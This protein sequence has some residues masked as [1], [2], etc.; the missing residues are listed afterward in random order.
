MTPSKTYIRFKQSKSYREK[1]A[2][3]LEDE[4]FKL[5]LEAVGSCA[6]PTVMPQAVPGQAYDITIAHMLHARISFYLLP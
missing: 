2:A 6:S 3:L 1:I 5:A 4:V